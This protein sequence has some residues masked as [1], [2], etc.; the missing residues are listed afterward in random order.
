MSINENAAQVCSQPPC[1]SY[2]T[3]THTALISSEIGPSA[4]PTKMN[5]SLAV[6]TTT[7]VIDWRT[8]MFFTCLD[9]VRPLLELVVK[10]V[11]LRYAKNSVVM[12]LLKQWESKVGFEAKTDWP[13]HSVKDYQELA[14]ICRGLQ[15]AKVQS[16]IWR[17]WK[18]RVRDPSEGSNKDRH[19]AAEVQVLRNG[20]EFLRIAAELVAHEEVADGSTQAPSSVVTSG[21]KSAR[22]G[23]AFVQTSV[24]YSD[25][26]RSLRALETLE[27][28]LS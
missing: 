12:P 24:A 20:L 17:L 22:G 16:G 6:P 14:Q 2:E 1:L 4:G 18:K 3:S 23:S 28:T 8:T 27:S 9:E 15:E 21:A 19:N 11:P 25:F 5:H 10:S 7:G 13:R 26:Q